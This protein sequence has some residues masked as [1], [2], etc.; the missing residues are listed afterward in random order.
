VRDSVI[1]T[2]SQEVW[3]IVPMAGENIGRF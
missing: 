2:R 3:R 1:Y